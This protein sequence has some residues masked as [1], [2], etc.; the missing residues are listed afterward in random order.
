MTTTTEMT[1]PILIIG[2]TGKT[3]R[4]VADRL[5]DL[6]VPTR[7]ASRSSAV[8]FDWTDRTTWAPALD[9][10][11]PV[12]ITY[13][14]DLIVAQSAADLGAFVDVAR[15][16]GVDRLVLLSGRG[17]P[18]AQACEQIVLHSGVPATVLRCS[19]F[20]QNFTESFLAEGVSEGAVVL[21][22]GAVGEPFIDADD[23]ADAAV[24]ALTT[25]GHEGRVYEL[26][27]PRLLTFAEA[28]NEIATVTGREIDYVTVSLDDYRA[29]MDQAGVPD[30]DADM[31][32]TLFGT[33][34]DGRNESI[35]GGVREI[36]GR[37]P[38]DFVDVVDNA[39]AHRVW[40]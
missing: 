20:A 30:H 32:I 33:L 5:A 15:R 27:G 25:A 23:I 8:R 10:A 26:T 9:G 1:R 14:P 21:P 28:T 39:V 34:F 3:G 13:Q 16:A 18:E 7:L 19:W 22:V 24:V 12:Y 6:D 31:I 36:L 29:G 37:D 40:P 11:G 17:E 35:T 2:A 38:H 4:R